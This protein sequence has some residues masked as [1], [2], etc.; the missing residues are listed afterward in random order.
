MPDDDQDG[1]GDRDLSLA[2][3]RRRRIRWYRSLRKVWDD[4]R[5]MRDS[6]GRPERLALGALPPLP[7]RVLTPQG[8]PRSVSF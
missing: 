1:A 5:K 2:L 4:L 8:D 3:P 6:S 7:A